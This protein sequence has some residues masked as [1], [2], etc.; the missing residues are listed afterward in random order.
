MVERNSHIHPIAVYIDEP[1]LRVLFIVTIEFVRFYDARRW[2]LYWRPSSEHIVANPWRYVVDMVEIH[3]SLP[4]CAQLIEDDLYHGR[5]GFRKGH[6]VDIVVTLTKLGAVEHQ[7]Q[8][9]RETMSLVSNVAEELADLSEAYVFC[10]LSYVFVH[11]TICNGCCD[12][13]TKLLNYRNRHTGRYSRRNSASSTPATDSRCHDRLRR[14][15]LLC[16]QNTWI[17]KLRKSSIEP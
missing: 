6:D 10:S 8:S 14:D 4:V 13:K 15:S 5:A 11:K 1:T 7:I 16:R 2:K 17:H 3:I 12:K 9:V